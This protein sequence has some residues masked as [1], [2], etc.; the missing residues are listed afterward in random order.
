M[1]ELLDVLNEQGKPTGLV[2]PRK[3]IQ[4]TGEW[5]KAAHVWIINLQEEVLITRRS[6]DASTSPGAWTMSAGGHVGA[7]EKSLDCAQR[8]LKEEVGA[9]LPKEKFKYLFT[10]KF[11]SGDLFP[12]KIV[13]QFNDVFLVEADIPITEFKVDPKEVIDLKYVHY[14]DLEEQINSEQIEMT[15]QYEQFKML[16]KY[17]A[18]KI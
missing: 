3:E 4:Q 15:P 2:K 8:E 12:G 6:L 16:F 5:H 1:D 14:K 18:Q 11:Q 10:T 9:E 7:G 17:L 13:N